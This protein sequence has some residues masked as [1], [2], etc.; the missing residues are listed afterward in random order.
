[1]MV[2]RRLPELPLLVVLMAVVSVSMVLP[3]AHALVLSQHAVA[4]AFFYSAIVLMIFTAM[5]GIAMS[6]QRNTLPTD[7]KLVSVLGTYLALPL[8]MAVPVQQALPGLSFGQAWFE[9]LSSFTTTGASLFD[10][11]GDISAPIHFWRALVGW[12]GGFYS[13]LVTLAILVPTGLGGVE[14]MG[15]RA[16]DRGSGAVQITK[17]AETSQRIAHYTALVLP[18]YAGLTAILWTALL[19]AGD[20]ALIALCHA[21]GTLS[22]SGISPITGLAGTASGR[23]GEVL[24]FI[25]FG[26]ALTRRFW[27]G[28]IM[29]DR[30]APLWRD[31]ELRLAAGIIV[32]V[33]AVLGLYYA[34]FLNQPV[35][36]IS[37][38]GTARALWGTAFTVLS[39]LTT[40][41]FTSADWPEFGGPSLFLLGLA[42]LGGGVATTAGGIK[43]LRVYALLRHGERE[44]ERVVHPHSIGGHGS[45]ARRLRRQGAYLAW[46]FF[47]IFGIS[48]AAI[49]AVLTLTGLE[50]SP[51]MV[52]AV[53]GLSNTGPLLAAIAE[54]QGS[55]ADLGPSQLA[56]LG[57]SMIL[58]RIEILAVFVVFTRESWAR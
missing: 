26:F 2:F 3:A 38:V 48:I 22:S 49:T 57:L 46:I 36:Q 43:L 40:T 25:C 23:T 42:I 54:T 24:I 30:T 34:V 8:V 37:A 18:V 33:T 50:F 12:F 51:A 41:G 1:M 21:M 28:T 6:A 20:S 27:P 29:S 7:R 55:Y 14:L 32:A 15:G 19:I 4:R 10:T 39:F 45:E 17:I 53:A 5:I 9:M 31:P 58:G 44:L 13:L 35:E 11:P 47:M 56:V 16:P 52:L